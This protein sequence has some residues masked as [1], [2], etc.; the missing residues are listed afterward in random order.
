MDDAFEPSAGQVAT[1]I[2]SIAAEAHGRVGVACSLPGRTLDCNLNASE[3]L[4]MQSVYKLP[5]AMATLHSVEKGLF[6]LSAKLQFL[7]TDVVS[8]DQYSSL[9]AAHP[10]GGVAV[11]V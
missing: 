4:P 5:I 10:H 2:R 7:S 11:P 3:R 1:E 6:S 9:Q 8:P